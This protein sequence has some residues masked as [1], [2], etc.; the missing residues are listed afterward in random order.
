MGQCFWLTFFAVIQQLGGIKALRNG[1]VHMP[2]LIALRQV[3]AV[4]LAPHGRGPAYLWAH[5]PCTQLQVQEISLVPPQARLPSLPNALADHS[6][7]PYV[8]TS[9]LLPF[10]TTAA[11][12][13]P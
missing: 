3:A 10:L 11:F 8:L 6:F 2:S 5:F 4:R 9:L 12:I 1:L 7:A 13:Q